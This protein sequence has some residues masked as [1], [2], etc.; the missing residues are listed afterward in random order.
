MYKRSSRFSAFIRALILVI[1]PTAA[2]TLPAVQ[3]PT[4]L[5]HQDAM[6]D[7]T[8]D[9]PGVRRLIRAED[10]PPAYATK[11]VDRGPHVVPRPAGAL[12]KVPAGFEVDLLAEGLK[13]PRRI[14]T[15]P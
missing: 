10:L 1:A 2:W 12:P 14:T 6:G 3:S 15:A 5:E 11:S 8:T 7:W 9:A 13:N 4:L